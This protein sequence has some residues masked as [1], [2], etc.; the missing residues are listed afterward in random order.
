MEDSYTE[1]ALVD[2]I[3]HLNKRDEIHGILVQLPLPPSFNITHV[4][5]SISPTKDV[6]GFHSVN[7]GELSKRSGNPCFI[8]CTAKGVLYLVKKALLHLNG[9]ESLEGKTAVVVGRSDIVGTPT[10][11]LLSKNNATVIICHSKTV[12]LRELIGLADVLVV[13]I[14][15]PKFI[16]G[17]WIRSGAIVIDVGINVANGSITGDVDYDSMIGKAGAITPVPG[18]VGPLTVAM[19]MENTISSAESNK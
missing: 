4:M 16:N 18:G 13:A 14:G 15:Q 8:P 19:L 9:N 12:N 17:E 11:H 2:L 1:S 5:N 3:D 6:D 10:A 7:V